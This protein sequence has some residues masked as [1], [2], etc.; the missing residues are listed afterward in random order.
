VAA[1]LY[2]SNHHPENVDALLALIMNT[3]N[4]FVCRVSHPEPGMKP[5]VYYKILIDDFNVQIS[6]ILDQISN[7][8]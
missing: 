5:K 6:E 7:Q 1:A 3:Y 4:D 8:G 2:D